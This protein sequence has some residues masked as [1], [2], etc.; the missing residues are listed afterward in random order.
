MVLAIVVL[1]YIVEASEQGRPRL[2]QSLDFRAAQAPTPFRVS[3]ATQL[4]YEIH[5]S[6]FSSNEA[7]VV[8]IVVRDGDGGSLLE[9]DGKELE[10]V[11]RHASSNPRRIASG[12]QTV[13]FIWFALPHE[14]PVPSTLVHEIEFEWVRVDGRERS[15]FASAPLRVLQEPAVAIGPPL[16]GGPWV[17]LYDPRMPRGHRT[18]IY[19]LDG[20]ARIPARYAIDWVRLAPD[21]THAKPDTTKVANWHGYGEDVL[22][23]ADGIVID[24]RDDMPAADTV[25]AAQGAMPLE[26]AS[27]NYVVL[28]IGGGRYA[29]YEHLQHGSVRVTRGDR[30]RKGDVIASL[31]N[32]G[33]SSSG[34][35][36]HFH[37]ADSPHTLAAEGVPFVFESFEVIGRFD[38]ID[39]FV[40]GK[41]WHATNA[42]S[43]RKREHPDTNVVLMFEK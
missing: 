33:S 18:S 25:G 4:A 37:L 11:L 20:R 5:L 19:T 3:G 1:P 43:V 41:R 13:V 21:G 39:A 40:T 22:A 9:L 2:I 6:N 27:G 38:S 15:T 24:A 35:H 7:E 14:S 32:S 28:D 34:P 10:T 29:F 30:V 36:L 17:A 12:A 16:R 31:G 42:G 23:V 8:R 26:E